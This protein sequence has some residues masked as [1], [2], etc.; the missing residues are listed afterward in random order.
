MKCSRMV[1]VTVAILLAVMF[2]GPTSKAPAAP[3]QGDAAHDLAQGGQTVKGYFKSFDTRGS[4]WTVTVKPLGQRQTRTYPLA[5]DP[6]IAYRGKQIPWQQGVIIDS[7]VEL[8]L[9]Q[10]E[11]KVINVLLWSS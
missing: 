2:T 7:L 10:G 5:A 8:L 1:P 9:E 3:R 11:V 6:T 4:N